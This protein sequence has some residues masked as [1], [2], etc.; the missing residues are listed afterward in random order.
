MS[1]TID[2]PAHDALLAGAHTAEISTLVEALASDTTNGLASTESQARLQ[3]HG[4]NELDAVTA[5]PAWRKFIAQFQDLLILIL[6]GAALVSFLVSGE[7]KTPLVVLVVVVFNAV[8]GFI[9]EF[10]AEKSL[11]ALRKMLSATVRV[12]RDGTTSLVGVEEIVPGDIVL[13]EAGDRLPADG[14]IVFANNV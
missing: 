14:R 5:I 9:Q 3:I 12:R 11:D 1:T 13:V 4:R 6:L 7:L 2:P 10:R 8:L